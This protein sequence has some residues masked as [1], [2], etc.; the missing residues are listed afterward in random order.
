MAG[1]WDDCRVALGAFV[2]PALEIGIDDLVAAGDDSPARLRLPRSCRQRRAE[3]PRSGE[4]LRLRSE[5]RAIARQIRREQFG[6]FHR[7]EVCEL[8][9]R[10]FDGT[11]G[12]SQHAW[13]FLAKRRLVFV[14]IGGVRSDVNE[15]YDLWMNAGFGDDRSAIAVPDEERGTVLEIE[16]PLRRRD[17]VGKRC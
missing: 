9:R 3:Y 10:D 7:V 2:V 13:R 12:L 17:I 5:L 1:A 14:D 11:F 6:E 16:N 4:N 8:F 15:T